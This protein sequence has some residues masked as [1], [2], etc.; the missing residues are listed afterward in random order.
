MSRVRCGCWEEG[1]DVY[2]DG[3]CV[4]ED[5]K[6]E[7][8]EGKFCELWPDDN[9]LDEYDDPEEPAMIPHRVSAINGNT[10][11]P[12][13]LMVLKRLEVRL[14]LWLEYRFWPWT[15]ELF[16]DS[17]RISRQMATAGW[18]IGG[19]GVLYVLAHVLLAARRGFFLPF[20]V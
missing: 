17:S 13:W 19:L 11:R 6:V 15:W 14:A 18:L 2:P 10:D 12:L 20:R 3:F 5:G 4:D 16:R 8:C 9:G 1:D 7:P